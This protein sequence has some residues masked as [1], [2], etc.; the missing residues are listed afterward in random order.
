MEAQKIVNLLGNADSESSKFATRKWDVITDQNNTFCGEGSE[1]DTTVK[2]KTKVIKWNLCD[3]S[4]EYILVTGDI[5]VTGGDANTRVALKN[6]APFIKCLTHTNDEHF[7]GANNLDIIMPMYNLIEY[8]IIIQTFQEVY[9]SLKEMNHPWQML[10]ILTMFLELIQHLLNTNQVFF[11]P[12]E[13]DDNGVS[14][15]VKIAVL[16][17]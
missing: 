11:K 6:C 2:F 12:L 14:K 7:D 3:C 13:D 16:L 15:T 8:S 10:K 17:K 5:A 1:D 4:D 9:G